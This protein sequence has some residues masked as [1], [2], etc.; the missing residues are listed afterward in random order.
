MEVPTG[1]Q[2]AGW[3]TH[4]MR[5]EPDVLEVRRKIIETAKAII[6]GNLL[7]IEGAR[8]IERL[9]WTAGPPSRS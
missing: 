5:N 9:H 2:Q 1:V 3:Q 7:F 6:S 4:G 8:L